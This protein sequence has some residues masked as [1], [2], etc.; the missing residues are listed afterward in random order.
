MN[1]NLCPRKCNAKRSNIENVGGYCK[2]PLKPTVARAALHYFEEPIISGKQGSGTVFF[3]GCN[4]GCMYCQNYKIS[5][6]GLG[7]TVSI[8]H[9][10]QIFRRLE[11]M[12]AVNINLVTP[13]HYINAVISALDIYRPKI[14]IVYNSSGYESAEALDMLKDYVDVYLLDFKYFKS[15][16]ALKYS[17]APDYPDVAKAAIL[18]AIS[19]KP[20]AVIKNNIIKSGVIVRHLLLPRAT[21]EAIKIFDFVRENA[22]GA[23]FSLM[24]QY[25]PL[26]EAPSDDVINRKITKRE[27]EKVTE[28]IL[29]SGFSNCF[30][31][32]LS[33]ADTKYIPAFDFEGV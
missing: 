13:T 23:Y 11:D 18:K 5:K 1:C 10:A 17:F 29:N 8:E 12:G 27:Y 3:S 19:Q 14:P 15:E 32:D 20:N 25:V 4:L 33:S 16:S 28:Y 22:K 30:I 24:S 2:A 31:Q 9:L 21:N 26:G 6:M 7:K